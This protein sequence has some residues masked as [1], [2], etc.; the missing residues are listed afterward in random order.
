MKEQLT[1]QPLVSVKMITYNH[2]PFIARAIEGV[3]QQKTDFSFELL[4]GEDCSTDGTREVV[5]EYQK[6]YPDVIRVITSD[7]NVGMKQNGLRVLKACRGK[8]IAYCEGDDYWHHPLKL[9]KQVDYLEGHQDCGLVYSNYDLYLVGLRKQIRDY[10]SYK[11]WEVPEK[12]CISDFVGKREMSH[13]IM[14]LTVMIRRA[15]CEQIMQADP[16]LHQDGSFL[17]GDTQLWAEVTTKARTH[18]IPES[19]ATYTITDESASRSKDIRKTLRFYISCDDLFIYLSNKYNVPAEL[20]NEHEANRLDHMLRLAFYTRDASLAEEVR[21][22]QKTLTW[23]EWMR[24][25]GARNL[26][27]Y[28]VYRTWSSVLGLFRNMRNPW[29]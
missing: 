21:Q 26:A 1:T 27:V 18:Y 12:P 9:Q 29:L 11:N 22:Q 25:Y 6:K 28:H 19:L 20:K 10:I 24:Y 3:M 15:L 8:Y 14:T 2:A 5:F 4:I 13:V 7:K 17:M 16:Y 23:K